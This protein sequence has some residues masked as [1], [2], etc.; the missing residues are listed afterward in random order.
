MSS[1]IRERRPTWELVD[2]FP[3]QGDWTVES[4]LALDT[5]KFIEYIDGFLEMLPVPEE[6]H[7]YVQNF[8]YVSVMTFL[9]ARG[10]GAAVYAPFKIRI[11]PNAFREPDVAIINEESDPRRASKYWGGADMVI[12]VVSPGGAA[13]DYF[14]KREDYAEAKIP[15]YWIVDPMKKEIHVLRL[16]GTEYAVRA[17]LQPGQIAESSVLQGFKL[18]VTHC[19]A[20]ADKASPNKEPAVGGDL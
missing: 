15:E 11:R 5:S 19:F 2:Y 10:K 4:Y 6:F 8:I 18:D 9:S 12:E 1:T 3:Q 14:E 7:V 17:I 13:R 16:A 20:A